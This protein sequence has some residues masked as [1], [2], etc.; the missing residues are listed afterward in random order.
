MMPDSTSFRAADDEEKSPSFPF[1]AA[2]EDFFALADVAV[3]FADDVFFGVD[4]F[5]VDEV[6]AFF[7]SS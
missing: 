3:F 7:A 5:L 6:V 2:E 4:L 1:V